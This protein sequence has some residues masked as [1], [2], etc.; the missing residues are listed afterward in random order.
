VKKLNLGLRVLPKSKKSVVTGVEMFRK[1]LDQGQAGDNVG[2]LLR[3]IEKEHV[4]R[5]QV[6]AKP[7]SSHYPSY[8]FR[9]RSL[10]L[11]QR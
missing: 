5:G 10:Y 1:T 4:E 6:L 2:F 11:N 9:S 8:R 7:G 3:G